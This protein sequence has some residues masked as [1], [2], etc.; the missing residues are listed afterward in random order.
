M[1][2]V[3]AIREIVK[4]V[5]MAGIGFCAASVWWARRMKNAKREAIRL[6]NEFYEHEKE[7][8][9]KKEKACMGMCKV[10][11]E[12]MIRIRQER[13]ETRGTVDAETDMNL[14]TAQ[15]FIKTWEEINDEKL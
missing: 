6:L 2:S 1:E 11:L 13:L 8:N 4:A 3:E 12:N 9:V 7:R 14:R 15:D 10:L 5:C